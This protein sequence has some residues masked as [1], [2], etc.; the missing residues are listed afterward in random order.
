[1]TVRVKICGVR[2][3]DDARAAAAAG[4]DF[5]GLNFHPR[6]PALPRPGGGPRELAARGARR[7]ALVGVFVDPPRAE[8]ERIAARRRPGGASSSTAT[9][10]PDYCRGWPWRTI[11]ALR[12]RR[13]TTSRRLPP[14]YATDYLLPDSFVPGTAGRHRRGARSRRTR[15]ACP[16]DRL[17]VAGGLRPETVA[18]VVRARASLRG[19]R[20]VRRRAQRPE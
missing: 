2:T 13:A 18:E 20:R 10:T 17:F 7:R 11:K 6:E 4:A 1:M 12:V 3:A 19:R 9:R 16:P 14:R 8:V 15:P 5:L